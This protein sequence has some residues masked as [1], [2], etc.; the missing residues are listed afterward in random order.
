MTSRPS[1]VEVSISASSS[2]VEQY[3][4]PPWVRLFSQFPVYMLSKAEQLLLCI[5][6]SQCSIHDVDIFSERLNTDRNV[7]RGKVQITQG[8]FMFSCLC[9]HCRQKKIKVWNYFSCY[10]SVRTKVPQ[11]AVSSN[12]SVTLSIQSKLKKRESANNKNYMYQLFFLFFSVLI[13]KIVKVCVEGQK[14]NG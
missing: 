6:S 14:K 12:I 11:R 9:S 1:W 10:I 2:R 7:G 4:A 13:S 5:S 3:E 8:R